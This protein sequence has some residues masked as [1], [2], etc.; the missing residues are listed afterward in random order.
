MLAAFASI[1]RFRGSLE[2]SWMSCVLMPNAGHVQA[3]QRDDSIVSRSDA[4]TLVLLLAG[5]GT[6]AR[7]H[8]C[9]CVGDALKSAAADAPPFRR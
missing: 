4:D 7:K 6:Y 2:A 8:E 5:L 1:R 9:T 3:L